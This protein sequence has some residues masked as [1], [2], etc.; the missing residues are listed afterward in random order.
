[1]KFLTPLLAQYC[2][3]DNAITDYSFVCIATS[4]P[5]YLA[6]K[7]GG[8]APAFVI[9]KLQ[10]EQ[11]MNTWRV[12]QQL[13]QLLPDYI[14]QPLGTNEINGELFS[15]EKGV[16]GQPWFQI[17]QSYATTEAWQ[18]LIDKTISSLS[19]FQHA[20]AAHP[21]WRATET[22]QSLLMKAFNGYEAAGN[23]TTPQLLDYYQLHL[24]NLEVKQQVT[25]TM[26]HG[27]FSLNNLLVGADSIT[28]IDF[29]DFGM[30]LLPF[31]DEFNLALSLADENSDKFS[32]KRL[33]A[34]CVAPS[35][36]QTDFNKQL[37][38]MFFLGFL[39]TKLGSWSASEKRQPHRAWLASVLVNY[40]NAP[41]RYF[42]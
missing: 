7:N 20:V 21:A 3:N 26:Q 30:T 10:D 17:G 22:V 31:Y 9:K 18:R 39:L 41:E 35:L 14:A 6:I 4:N 37:L 28:I 34:S 2:E 33:I 1:M 19:A 11:A 32:I 25:C 13:Y 8:F 36:N 12:H 15:V 23:K 29:E 38:P 24:N 42:D 16:A 5:V 40:L 27:D